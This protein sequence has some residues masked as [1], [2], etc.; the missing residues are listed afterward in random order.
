MSITKK[1]RNTILL[2]LII[3]ELLFLFLLFIKNPFPKY[4]LDYVN[5]FKNLGFTIFIIFMISIICYI[6]EH[7]TYNKN[8][9][10]FDE[11]I[12][13]PNF[14]IALKNNDILYLSTILKQQYPEKKEIILLI[15]QLI[16]KKIIDL[17]SYWDGKKYQYFI[18]KRQSN[19]SQI[20]SIEK[21]LLY[22]LFKNSNK[23]NLISKVT[24]IYSYKNN[25]I[26]I[27]I[28]QIN[29][30]IKELKPIVYSPFKLLYK[31]LVLIL[32]ISIFV[33][34]SM[35]IINHSYLDI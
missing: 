28:K 15:M 30:Y 16:N 25:D 4:I 26:S 5:L 32:S 8:E 21:N 17:S 23:T 19:F 35:V 3:L 9:N 22:Y 33:F 31:I 20:N 7:K 14:D 27:L 29:S 11:H 1:I 10:I 34:R 18:E 24:E 2:L 12:V 13:E 6:L